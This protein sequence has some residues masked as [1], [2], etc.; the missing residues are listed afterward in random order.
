[1]SLD[2]RMTHISGDE[3]V[4]YGLRRIEPATDAQPTRLVGPTAFL[5]M[6][7]PALI[8]RDAVLTLAQSAICNQSI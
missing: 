5:E 4:R 8:E 3:R 2:D 6:V 7:E 1:M